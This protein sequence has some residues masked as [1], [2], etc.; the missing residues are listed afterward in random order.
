MA[1]FADRLTPET[2]TLVMCW[3]LVRGDG[4]ALG[5]TTHDAPL[6]I[7][8]L[9]FAAAPGMAPSAISSTDGIDVDTMDV[10]GALTA[11]TVT[12]V[13][14]AAGRFDG[15]VVSVFMVDW[16]AIDAGQLQLARGK[17]GEVVH[18][19]GGGA[20]SFTAA[21]RGPTAEFE[22]T[23]I[24]TYSPE[25]RA[26][27]GDRRC[28]IDLAGRARAAVVAVADSRQTITMVET[29]AA[30]AAYVGG[31]FR[32][33]SGDNAGIDARIIAADAAALTLFEPLPFD[34]AA[35]T[36]V[37]LREGCDKS[38]ATCADRFANAVNF[39]GEPHVPGGDVLTRFPG[40]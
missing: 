31:R 16:Q 13:D 18:H 1:G 5:F 28:R 3:R 17:L 26:E 15:A 4:V 12:A 29:G 33:L 20:G 32:A 10:A 34:V 19:A 2:T 39:R 11:D 9:R 24:E 38:I 37:E 14:L 35:G 40:V 30:L 8:G 23:A 7:D 22:A 36:R 25:C 27:L 21:L 6:M